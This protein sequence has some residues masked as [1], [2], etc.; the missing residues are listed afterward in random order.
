MIRK[1]RPNLAAGKAIAEAKNRSMLRGVTAIKRYHEHAPYLDLGVAVQTTVPST[2]I[3][4]GVISGQ[5]SFVV[6]GANASP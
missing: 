4:Q 1:V 3:W 6:L 2:G 5:F